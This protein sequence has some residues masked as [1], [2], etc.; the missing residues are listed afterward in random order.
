[1]SLSSLGHLCAP[2]TDMTTSK[3]RHRKAVDTV[4]S[5]SDGRWQSGCL[6]VAAR[7]QTID[8]LHAGNDF[9]DVVSRF[10]RSRATPFMKFPKSYRFPGW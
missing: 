9:A 4:E 7:G 10:E 1:M 3:R 2:N 5:V 8:Y 6:L